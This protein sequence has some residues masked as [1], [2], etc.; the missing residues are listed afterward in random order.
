MVIAKNILV[1]YLYKYPIVSK[2]KFIFDIRRLS[3]GLNA[4]SGLIDTSRELYVL[5]DSAHAQ[6]GKYADI[7]HYGYFESRVSNNSRNKSEI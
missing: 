7:R 3:D 2:N 4:F 5:P 6:C 1:T